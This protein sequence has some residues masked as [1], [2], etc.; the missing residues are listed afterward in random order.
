MWF[1]ASGQTI[2]RLRV[3]SET[4]GQRN[5]RLPSLRNLA[6]PKAATEP[7]PWLRGFKGLRKNSGFQRWGIPGASK[8]AV[9]QAAQVRRVQ[10]LQKFGV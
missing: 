7:D 10:N 2:I 5:P 3:F 9:P 1:R 8:A 4:S 6:K